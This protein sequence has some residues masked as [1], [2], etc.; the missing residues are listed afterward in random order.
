[1]SDKSNEH[2]D[3]QYRLIVPFFPDGALGV[4]SARIAPPGPGGLYSYPRGPGH[5]EPGIYDMVEIWEAMRDG[6]LAAGFTGTT[7][8]RVDVDV[9][10]LPSTP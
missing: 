4:L 8:E 6:L 1:M 3:R 5:T 10:A 9:T 2:V 7:L